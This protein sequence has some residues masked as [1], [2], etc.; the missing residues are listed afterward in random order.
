MIDFEKATLLKLARI[1]PRDIAGSVEP[2]IVPGEEL[3]AAFKTVRDFVVFTNKRVIAVNVQGMT[4]KKKD[5]TSLPY[6]K[7]QA[8]SVE[9][10]GHFDLDAELDLWFSGLGKVRFE[11]RGESD[12]RQISQLIGSYVL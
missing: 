10:A 7:I 3:H 4:G 5:Y 1:D 6:S 2:L 8:F 11:F 9:T 12:I